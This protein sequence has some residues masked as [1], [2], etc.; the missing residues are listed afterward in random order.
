MRCH[1]VAHPSGYALLAASTSHSR[2]A[3][4]SLWPNKGVGQGLSHIRGPS[5]CRLWRRL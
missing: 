1:T 3:L 5:R 2:L 4:G